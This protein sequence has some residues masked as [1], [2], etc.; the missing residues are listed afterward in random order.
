MRFGDE[1]TPLNFA[2]IWSAV[3]LFGTQKVRYIHIEH[4]HREE[5][6][7]LRNVRFIDSYNIL[8]KLGQWYKMYSRITADETDSSPGRKD[9]LWSPPSLLI[10]MCGGSF[11]GVKRPGREADHSPHLVSKLRS[12]AIPLISL[13]AFMAWRRT[14][15]PLPCGCP[16]SS[17]TLDM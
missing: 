6:H 11:P 1:K 13:Y 14:N 12:R 9:R 2:F 17:V 3:N 15:L 4:A 10:N 5:S 8:D 16:L 7:I